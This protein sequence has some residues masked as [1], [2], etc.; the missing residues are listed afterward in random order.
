MAG[1]LTL[2]GWILWGAQGVAVLL[3]AGAIGVL[4]NP[5]VSFPLLMRFYGGSRI[6]RH[7]A[8]ELSTMLS[9]LAERAGLQ[10]APDLYY[11]PSRV[12]N[13]FAV[14]G[15]GGSA[16]AVSDGLLRKLGLRELA[17]ALAH[18]ISHIR[19]NDLWVLALADMFSRTTRLLSLIGQFLLFLNLPLILFRSIRSYTRWSMR[20]AFIG[21]TV[22]Y[23]RP[24]IG[25]NRNVP[26]SEKSFSTTYGRR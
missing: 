15:R 20:R 8:P 10:A 1:F 14:G 16:I 3:T 26:G 2:L 11:I 25:M 13:A 5:A 4:F 9:R 24:S 19:S 12:V 17:G 6:G 7:Q 22:T 18:Q 21:R 23:K